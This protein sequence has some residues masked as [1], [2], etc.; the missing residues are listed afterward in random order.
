MICLS[1]IFF[2]FQQANEYCLGFESYSYL[3]LDDRQMYMDQFITYAR[4]LTMEE[5]DLVNLGDSL[6]PKPVAPTMA[7]YKEQVCNLNSTKI[8]IIS[9]SRSLSLISQQLDKI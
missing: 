7:Q 2:V 8:S 5:M 3:W 9:F 6:A 4:Q 1:Y